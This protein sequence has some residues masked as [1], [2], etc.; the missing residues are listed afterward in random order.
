MEIRNGTGNLAQHCM[1]AGDIVINWFDFVVVAVVTIG[2]FRGRKRG[3]SEE[4]LDLLKSL[5]IVVAAALLYR[6]VGKS[7]ADYTHISPVSSYVLA[8]LAVLIVVRTLFGWL[9]RMVGEK[10]LGSDVFGSGEYYLGMVA[11]AGRFTCYLIMFLAVLNAA[12]LT[13]DQ[14]AAQARRQR[15]SFEDISF[16]TLGT[17]QHTVFTGSASGALVKQYL[18]HELIITTAADKNIK[19]ADTLGRQRERAISDIIGEKK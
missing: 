18:A 4:L 7:V 3:M 12:Y 14:L 16:P 13:P 9:K 19:P 17:L 2:I 6:P 10:L 11:G 15:E 5:A 8:Y 1:K